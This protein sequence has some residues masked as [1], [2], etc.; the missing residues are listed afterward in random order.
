MAYG[1]Y[2]P[3]SGTVLEAPS[4]SER[5]AAGPGNRCSRQNP[6]MFGEPAGFMSGS[7]GNAGRFADYPPTALPTGSCLTGQQSRACAWAGVN[8][9]AESPGLDGAN[10]HAAINRGV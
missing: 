3:R 7:A 9:T 5:G 6:G 2:W 4:L 10:S 1:L 8:L